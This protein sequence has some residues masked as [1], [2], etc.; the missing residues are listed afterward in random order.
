MAWQCR[1]H[2]YLAYEQLFCRYSSPFSN[3]VVIRRPPFSPDQNLVFEDR[4]NNYSYVINEARP[5]FDAADFI[6]IGQ[7]TLLGQFSHVTNT[8]GADYLRGCLEGTGVELYMLETTNL[9]AMHIDKTVM[10]LR[11]GLLMY[12][13]QH[14]SPEM[15]RQVPALRGWTFIEVP[16]P[17]NTEDNEFYMDS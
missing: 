9:S 12:Q 1:S 2:E 4:S 15:L 7:N 11:E 13:P 17:A 16:E 10:P 5:A 8:A 3:S 6:R 14:V